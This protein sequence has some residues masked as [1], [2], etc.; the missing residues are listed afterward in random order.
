MKKIF[1]VFAAVAVL[2]AA[3]S[4]ENPANED[5]II[6]AATTA[7]VY[8]L[9]AT[10][11]ATKATVNELSGKFEWVSNDKIAVYDKEQSKYQIFTTINSGESVTFS[12]T[13]TDGLNH[14]FSGSDAYYP[15]SRLNSAQTDLEPQ[16][17]IASAGDVPMKA[18]NNGGSLEFDYEAAVVKLTVNHVPSFTES[19]EFVNDGNSY[20]AEVSHSSN[21]DMV[22]YFV[23]AES[24]S[25]SSEI[26]LYDTAN[27]QFVAKTFN[28]AGGKVVKGA[29][30]PLKTTIGPVVLIKNNSV[31]EAEA[32]G[33]STSGLPGEIDFYSSWT[34]GETGYYNDDVLHK[35]TISGVEYSYY[36]YPASQKDQTVSVNI[37]HDNYDYPRVVTSIS[38]NENESIY[39]FGYT[40]GLRKTT[41][42]KTIYAKAENS[43]K[44]NVDY[45]AAHVRW[46]DGDTNATLGNL[47][48]PIS[49]KMGYIQSGSDKQR[50]WYF[51]MSGFTDT[52][53]LYFYDKTNTSNKST[54]YYNLS[55]ST[56]HYYYYWAHSDGGN[57]Y[58]GASVDD[59]S[60]V[61]NGIYAW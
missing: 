12:F 19:V 55:S 33:H 17:T 58:F 9:S 29:L 11:P 1:F 3:C 37:H 22:F 10:M 13:A 28:L 51:D 16:I 15:A 54:E 43:S 21:E 34:G 31:A 48:S 7:K 6:P 50:V 56:D 38:L 36:V 18:T 57:Y 5:S 25:A 23:V 44:D 26:N 14:D 20:A 49:T 42:A 40:R 45:L 52:F 4:K 61:I 24:N 30:I 27:N 8:T 32:A 35:V 47:G 39:Y 59:Q 2:F 60:A 46:G 53:H 41:T